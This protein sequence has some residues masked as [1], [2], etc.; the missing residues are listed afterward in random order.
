MIVLLLLP[1]MGG[2]VSVCRRFCCCF[3]VVVVVH[4]LNCIKLPAC[5]F[6]C[7][8]CFLLLFC[9]GFII[10]LSCCP[11]CLIARLF[12]L[13]DKCIGVLRAHIHTQAYTHSSVVV[14]R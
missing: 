14:W 5:L 12:L 9:V 4:I 7:Q 2:V 10:L 11:L 8:W 3:G 1:W 13:S 6:C